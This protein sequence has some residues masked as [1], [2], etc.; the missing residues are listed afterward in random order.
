VA[1][2]AAAAGRVAGDRDA[3]E[4]ASHVLAGAVAGGA[5][6]GV[7]RREQVGT[8]D[9]ALGA[10]FDHAGGGEA[11]VV[12]ALDG[13]LHERVELPVAERRPPLRQ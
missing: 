9:A 13:A 10:G 6:G 4:T 11:Q 1:A 5:S 7:D 8:D 12:V 3:G 2:A